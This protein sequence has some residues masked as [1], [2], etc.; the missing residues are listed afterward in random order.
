MQNDSDALQAA[1]TSKNEAQ[2]AE[3]AVTPRVRH[4]LCKPVQTSA[5]KIAVCRTKRGD[6]GFAAVEP[7]GLSGRTG[8]G[9]KDDI[10]RDQ[11][12]CDLENRPSWCK[13]PTDTT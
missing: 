2:I 10:R 4:A 11:Y 8:P 5:D 6:S 7:N 13:E 1:K 3:E 12:S 9:G